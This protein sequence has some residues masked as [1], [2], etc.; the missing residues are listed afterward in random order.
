MKNDKIL[1]SEISR[2]QTLMTGKIILEQWTKIVD[3]VIEYAGKLTGKLSDDTE[4]LIAKF[5]RATTDDDI[6]KILADIANSS[7]EMAAIIIPKIMGTISDAELKTI[8]DFKSLLKDGL[9][10][11]LDADTLKASA[12]DWVNKNVTSNFDGVKTV[13]KKDLLDYVDNIVAK[14]TPTPKPKPDSLKPKVSSV[15]DVA[16]Q[17]WEDII[18]ISAEELAKLEKLYRQK[19]LGKSFFKAMRSFAQ[20]VIDMM[21]S[22][23]KLMDETLSLIKTY[24]TVT[25]AAQK[26]DIGKKIGDNLR[27][28]TNKEKENYEVINKWIDINVLDYKLKETLKNLDGY[29]KATSIFDGTALKAWKEAYKGLKER[30]KLLRKQTKSM[31]NPISWYPSVMKKWSGDNYWAKVANKWNSFVKGPE[32]AELRRYIASGQ[33]QKWSG[34]DKFRK[35][36][37]FMPAIG[38]IAKEYTYSYIALAVILGG[39]DYISDIF[40]NVVRDWPTFTQFQTIKNQIES[41]DEHIGNDDSSDTNYSQLKGWTLFATDILSYGLDE[42]KVGTIQFPGL[43]D[44]FGSLLFAIRSGKVDKETAEEIT[45][46]A[47]KLKKEAQSELEKLEKKGTE[48]IDKAKSSVDS[49]NVKIPNIETYKNDLP[50]F[51]KWFIKYMEGRNTPIGDSDK[52]YIKS[53]ENGVYTFEDKNGKIY[54][55]EYS[56][57]TFKPKP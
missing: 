21:K 2:I 18:P 19:G 1:I 34:I 48:V 4:K 24:D 10:K 46:R 8:N 30:R 28:L 16:G 14:K 9:E 47:K 50:S 54:K 17:S 20:S 12:D 3:D 52:P 6:L 11:G 49:A 33:T 32:F 56:G 15:T 27:M 23:Y 26:T 25:N 53:P 22:Q 7:D 42:L 5:S 29:K 57:I 45:D 13:I 44:N 55:Y 41:Y 38:N 36:F 37:G 51:T 31:L 35:D 40:G 39:A 43:L